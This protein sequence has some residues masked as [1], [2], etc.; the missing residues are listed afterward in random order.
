MSGMEPKLHGLTK[1]DSSHHLSAHDGVQF[2]QQTV[3][4]MKKIIASP[5]GKRKQNGAAAYGVP[6]GE[7]M[8]QA[9]R[10][11]VVPVVMDKLI[12]FI[13]KHGLDEQGLFRVSGSAKVVEKIKTMFDRGGDIDLEQFM[14]DL[15]AVAGALKQFLRELPE[16]LIPSY[17]HSMFIRGSKKCDGCDDKLVEELKSLVAILPLTNRN[18]LKYLCSFL[19]TVAEHEHNNKMNAKGLGIVFGP[20]VFRCTMEGM[21]GLQEQTCTNVIVEKFVSRYEEIFGEPPSASAYHKSEVNSPMSPVGGVLRVKPQV[22]ASSPPNRPKPYRQYKADK[23]EASS[24]PKHGRHSSDGA[25]ERD[26]DSSDVNHPMSPKRSLSLEQ[27]DDGRPRRMNR[28]VSGGG[29]GSSPHQHHGRHVSAPRSPG[30]IRRVYLDKSLERDKTDSANGDGALLT[31]P[32]GIGLSAL[33]NDG[34]ADSP[35][36]PS[37]SVVTTPVP[38]SAVTPTS[39]AL[40]DEVIENTIR[41]KLLGMSI[42]DDG[43]ESAIGSLGSG[44]IHH[45]SGEDMAEIMAPGSRYG[46]GSQDTSTGSSRLFV[47]RKHSAADGSPDSNSE[48]DDV[49]LRGNHRPGR[50]TIAEITSAIPTIQTEDVSRHDAAQ[51]VDSFSPSRRS[52]SV[53]TTLSVGREA[54]A[55]RGMRST[56]QNG[57]SIAEEGTNMTGDAS[58]TGLDGSQKKKERPAVP[59]RPKGRKPSVDGD[60]PDGAIVSTIRGPGR[61]FDE[62]TENAEV[63]KPLTRE[64]PAG[65]PRRNGSL[66]RKGRERLA[67]IPSMNDKADN[68]GT[69]EQRRSTMPDGVKQKRHLPNIPAEKQRMSQSTSPS[70]ENMSTANGHDAKPYAIVMALPGLS[71]ESRTSRE[72]LQRP[73]T[74]SSSSQGMDDFVYQCKVP[75]PN[76]YERMD[77][78]EIGTHVHELK[79]VA[80][81]HDKLFFERFKRKA[82]QPDRMAI[83]NVIVSLAAAKKRLEGLKKEQAEQATLNETR[84]STSNAMPRQDPPASA[85]NSYRGPTPISSPSPEAAPPNDRDTNNS[86]PNVSRESPAFSLS[87]G[88]EAA[89]EEVWKAVLMSRRAAGRPSDIFE[90]TG[91]ELTDEKHAVQKQLLKYESAFGRPKTGE[92][93][94]LL[95]PVYEHYKVLK[96]EIERKDISPDAF[97][98][99]PTAIQSLSGTMLEDGDTFDSDAHAKAFRSTANRGR[100]MS[101]RIGQRSPSPVASGERDNLSRSL[102]V[103][104]ATDHL[105]SDKL[106]KTSVLGGGREG[107]TRKGS[108]ISE[109]PI[110]SG[111]MGDLKL[112]NRIELLEQ[113]KAITDS[114]QR[115]K[116]KL[117]QYEEDFFQ[118]TGR[119]VGKEDRGAFIDDYE[120]YKHAKAKLRVIE[121]LLAKVDTRSNETC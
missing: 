109:A 66:S 40:I 17:Q 102:P 13:T 76:E 96:R 59:Q 62:V 43:D 14:G 31:V 98:S 112:L 35:W 4:R 63:L 42:G 116:R 107:A 50:A 105:R 80:H 61:K 64:R 119:R 11:A 121:G 19:D 87:T 5:M 15:S 52:G 79:E 6:L 47:P 28:W 74:S 33:D 20:N 65:P 110:S 21:E 72:D 7:L 54:Q 32:N 12:D 36:S 111:W 18:I 94:R 23:Q 48:E 118:R 1:E 24:S 108:T 41:E 93:R 67:S 22:H 113:F 26:D 83:R 117:K 44:S 53:E 97:E 39:N 78:P 92:E 46:D 51:P 25:L 73:T 95:K 89:V 106:A 49:A 55:T 2:A 68:E 10:V 81:R 71:Q 58:D 56:D 90:M 114:K 9:G 57:R 34:R 86:A 101:D 100:I 103:A 70:P 16:P 99:P 30:V 27:A 75:T 88:T 115:V 82:H 84:P 91:R 120:E 77:V 8:I 3:A 60:T 69:P 45:F 29:N 85:A 104:S 38:D 37:G